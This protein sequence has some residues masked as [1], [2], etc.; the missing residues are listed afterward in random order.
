MSLAD[1]VA[2]RAGQRCEYCR[3]H[4]ELQGAVFHV[5]HIVP[6]TLG[7]SDELNNL[8]WACP[9]CNLTKANRVTITDP[10]TK[11]VVR[12]YHPRQDNWAEHFIWEGYELVGRTTIGRALVDAFNLNHVRR[13]R[14]RQVEA[15]FGLFPPQ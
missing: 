6:R 10:V 15:R 12:V 13:I 4:Q 3:M 14:V 9:G 11:Q 2:D 8:A 7:G 1:I 5:E